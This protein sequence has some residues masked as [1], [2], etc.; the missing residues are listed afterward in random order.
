MAE[1]VNVYVRNKFSGDWA[2]DIR[3]FRELPDGSRDI[4]ITIT[5]GEEEKILLPE[6]G[7]FLFIEPHSQ[8][9]TATSPFQ[10]CIF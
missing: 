8:A 9:D 4:D 7:V 10:V 6:L 1:Q 2:D 5:P 3:A